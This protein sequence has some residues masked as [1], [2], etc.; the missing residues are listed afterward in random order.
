VYAAIGDTA[1]ALTLL[2]PAADDR[3]FT[4][5]FLPYSPMSPALHGNPRYEK[6]VKQVG[7]IGPK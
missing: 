7:A 2:E 5:I 1:R 4:L 6:I 3:A